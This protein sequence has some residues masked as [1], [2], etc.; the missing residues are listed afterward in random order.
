[1][2]LSSRKMHGISGTCI[3]PSSYVSFMPCS[4][5]QTFLKPSAL[6]TEIEV[7]I[8]FHT[9]IHLNAFNVFC[10]SP[11][12]FSRLV[13]CLPKHLLFRHSA[14][15]PSFQ[16]SPIPTSSSSLKPISLVGDTKFTKRRHTTES[17]SSPTLHRLGEPHTTGV[18]GSQCRCSIHE[19]QN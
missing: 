18:R 15:V 5:V 1:M 16:C 14:H 6:T 12:L 7:Q 10:R 13:T 11:I 8:H 4:Y 19:P 9:A 3:I 17:S 2:C